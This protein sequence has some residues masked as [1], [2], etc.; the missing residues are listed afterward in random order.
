MDTL[1]DTLL[2]VVCSVLV[3]FRVLWISGDVGPHLHL[4]RAF[5][6]LTLEFL[7]WSST[8]LG[9]LSA[10]VIVFVSIYGYWAIR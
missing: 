2:T 4:S 3:F 6:T 9:D 5:L 1:M 7:T 8:Y 10:N